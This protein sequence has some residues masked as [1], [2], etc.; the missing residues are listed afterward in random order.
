MKRILRIAAAAALALPTGMSWHDARAA[1]QV[2][3]YPAVAVLANAVAEQA[4][5]DA[6]LPKAHSGGG[7]GAYNIKTNDTAARTGYFKFR[8]D[9]E[10]VPD[11]ANRVYFSLKGKS[12]ASQGSLA[13]SNK[14]GTF[15]NDRGETVP[16]APTLLPQ[17]V[18]AV[19]FVVDPY[20]IPPSNV[21]SS[22]DDGN[23]APNAV[24]NNRYT[25]WSAQ[26]TAEQ[27]QYITFD[28]G[29]PK[30]VGYV[31]IAFYNGDSRQSFFTLQ[32]SNDGAVWIDVASNAASSGA[33]QQVE[34]FDLHA[35]ELTTRYLR[36]VGHGNNSDNANSRGWNSITEFQAY[37]PHPDGTTPVVDAPY[38]EPELPPT[39]PYTQPGLTNP[40]G[41][42]Y[43]VHTPNPVTGATHD[44]VADF[45]A[46]PADN[47]N[48][49]TPAILAAIAAADSGDEVYF[50]NGT[51]NLISTMPGDAQTNF[52]L[53]NGVN[54]RGESEAG[55]VLKSDLNEPGN[56]RAIKAFNKNNIYISDLTITARYDGRYT[57]DPTSQNPGI[58]GFGNGIYIDQ[59]GD[60]GSYNITIERV[61][62]EHFQRMG[63]RIAKSHD[64]TV[65]HSTFRKATDVGG[66]GAGYGI[67][68]QG[69]PKVDTLGLPTDTRHV[70]IEHN[71][72]EGP[73]LRHGVVVQ[74]YAHNNLV[75][76][77]TF[78]ST[79]LDA[80]D[81]HGEDEYLN[82]VAFNH[83]E[84]VPR[85]GIGVGNTGG[86]PPL[87]NHDASGPGNY[88]H[89]NSVVN[90]RDGILVYM[91]S[92]GTRIEENLITGTKD[93]VNA[94]GIKILNGPGTI[95]KDNVIVGN[96]APGFWGIL[97]AHDPGDVNA[98][99][100]AGAGDPVDA[101]VTG[102][103]VRR[104]ANGLKIEA[105]QRITVLGN[106][107]KQNRGT[108]VQVDVPLAEHDLK[109]KK[110]KK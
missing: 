32:A 20:D 83:V 97:L 12:N 5:P 57:T 98:G 43:A 93:Y 19:D 2:T 9:A 25:R 8:V 95:V 101:T 92:P 104:N 39:E 62:I 65:R 54:L 80:I 41:T 100:G 99:T 66:G 73:Y 77:N 42:P 107:I 86:T 59:S 109:L 21:T 11:D 68:V 30:P 64:V 50:P 94:A 96:E 4:N 85:G 26:N 37:P 6:H 24:D 27:N 102:N 105:G 35:Y 56:S 16:R 75:A 22:A 28:L 29:E 61:T 49:D 74:Y 82:E 23:I 76:N 81:L 110:E 34:A 51:Y 18:E 48:D 7:D 108:N 44:V 84:N 69:T 17:K 1:E 55:T 45:G 14:T 3:A 47:E 15:A 90:T 87:S 36:Y 72:F 106:E 31:G 78:L 60:Q 58:G 88:I 89:R 91:G 33:S 40:D 79:Q 53:K 63:I 71:R 103:V 10:Q 46:D 70:L 67:A 13:F 52:Q 38:V